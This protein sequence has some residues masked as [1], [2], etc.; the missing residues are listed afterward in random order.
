[1]AYI[2]T[3]PNNQKKNIG[4]YSPSEILQLTKDGSWG[5][6]IEFIHHISAGGA[7]SV[8]FTSIKEARYNV[9]LVQMSN[10]FANTNGDSPYLRFSSDGGSSYDSSSSYSYAHQYTGA[11]NAFGEL[12][13][14]SSNAILNT[15]GRGGSTARRVNNGYI[16]LYNLGTSTRYSFATMHSQGTDDAGNALGY[17]GGAQYAQANTVNAIQFGYTGSVTFTGDFKIYGIKQ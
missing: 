3:Q 7:S 10:V 9:H 14:T 4:L 1:M 13:S 8:N 2:G 11:H 16:L 15:L 17:F 6:S 5:G 12:K